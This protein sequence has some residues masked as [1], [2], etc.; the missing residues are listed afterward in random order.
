MAQYLG[1]GSGKNGYLTVSGTQNIN[2]YTSC[3]GSALGL[4]LTVASSTGFVAGDLIMIH[5]SRGSTTTAVGTW[6]LN[7][8][9]SVGGATTLNLAIPLVNA[10]QDSGADQSQCV[11]VP[12]YFSVTVPTAT[13][14]APTAW[15]GNVGGICVFA[16]SGTT[17]VVGTINSVAKGFLC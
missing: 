16:C 11:L 15:D 8:V 12:E 6:E 17:N 1:L 4:S 14:L 3:T 5:K 9:A 7:R 13:T 10:Y 2:T